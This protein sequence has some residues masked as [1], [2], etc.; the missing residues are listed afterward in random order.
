[1]AHLQAEQFDKALSTFEEGLRHHP[2]HADLHFN[3]GTAYD[4]LNR[5]D[6]V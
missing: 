5:F 3:L 1:L 4:K 2:K 6:D